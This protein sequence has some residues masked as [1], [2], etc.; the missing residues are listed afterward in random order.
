[1]AKIKGVTE[2]GDWSEIKLQIVKDYAAAYST[3]LAHQKGIKHDYIDAFAG[4][5]FHL[6]KATKEFVLGSPLNALVVE[7]PFNELYLVDLDGEKTQI[8]RD[9]T[10]EFRNVHIFEGDASQVLLNEV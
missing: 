4:A 5:G 3:I 7:P 10:R 6:S 9:V 1:M 8:L 2:I